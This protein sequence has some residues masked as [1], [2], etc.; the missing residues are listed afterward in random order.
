MLQQFPSVDETKAPFVIPVG[1]TSHGS[2]VTSPA[3]TQL[4]C[5]MATA[6][7]VL[8]QYDQALKKQKLQTV[9]G[10]ALAIVDTINGPNPTNSQ[11]GASPDGQ[12]IYAIVGT[13]AGPGGPL[14]I[15]DNCASIAYRSVYPNL[16]FGDTNYKEVIPELLTGV[17]DPADTKDVA[18]PGYVAF[19]V[20]SDASSHIIE[21]HMAAMPQKGNTSPSA[22]AV[23]QRATK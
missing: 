16:A 1:A 13:V 3:D 17:P 6:E 11:Y 12:S 5:P 2:P 22:P 10:T 23:G 4:F 8:A 14:E 21:A 20:I 7:A 9:S 18:V 15:Q 19:L